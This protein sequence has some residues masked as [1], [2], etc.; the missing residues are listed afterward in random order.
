MAP[1]KCKR[2][3]VVA[4]APLRTELLKNNWFDGEGSRWTYRVGL[5]GG[6]V[7]YWLLCLKC[8]RV[9]W[10]F[11]LRVNNRHS[12]MG[13]VH[14]CRLQGNVFRL[15]VGDFY[16]TAPPPEFLASPG[17]VVQRTAGA[18]ALGPLV[19]R[20]VQVHARRVHWPCACGTLASGPSI[21]GCGACEDQRAECDFCLRVLAGSLASYSAME[22]LCVGRACG[23]DVPIAS[24]PT[25]PW[26][27]FP[28]TYAT[29]C[30]QPVAQL[31]ASGGCEM[32]GVT[33]P[34]DKPHVVFVRSA[35]MTDDAQCCN[36]PVFMCD[37]C[38]NKTAVEMFFARV[39]DAICCRLYRPTRLSIAERI[40]AVGGS[41]A[42]YGGHTPKRKR[43]RP[44][45]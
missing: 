25:T 23:C 2:C 27:H 39:L 8:H 29:R 11:D 33:Q 22:S 13:S 43:R 4:C 37:T 14:H 1:P 18:L 45:S 44:V 5:Y 17:A 32:C 30:R 3:E 19:Q 6:R 7:A 26:P 20:P 24:P 21:C 35:Y 12:A 28:L 42:A 15:T 38:W 9:E 34:S 40:A 16:L 10:P 31:Q 41:L 36:V